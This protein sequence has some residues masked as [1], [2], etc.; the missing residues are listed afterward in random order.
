MGKTRYSKAN[1]NSRNIYQQIQLYKKYCM[2]NSNPMS[3]TIFKKTQE[4]SN[5]IPAKSKKH[6]HTNNNNKVTG[7]NSHWSLTS[8]NISGLRFSI[9]RHKLMGWK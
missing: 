4:I 3:L 1:Q 9:K 6:T 8:L 2:E 5:S 7:I